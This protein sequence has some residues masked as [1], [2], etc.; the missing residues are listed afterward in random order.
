MNGRSG[1]VPLGAGWQACLL[2]GAAGLLSMVEPLGWGDTVAV[3]S[4]GRTH[5]SSGSSVKM[6]LCSSSL[7]QGENRAQC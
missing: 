5:S 6:A 4:W 3:G 1:I 7:G 2:Q